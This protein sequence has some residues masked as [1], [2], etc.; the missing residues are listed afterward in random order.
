MNKAVRIEVN[1]NSVC[2]RCGASDWF[3]VCEDARRAERV[4]EIEGRE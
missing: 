4:K 1:G 2:T 3:V